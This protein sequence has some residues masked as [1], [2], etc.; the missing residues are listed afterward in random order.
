METPQ[1]GLY[2]TKGRERP[3]SSSTCNRECEVRPDQFF[4]FAE[5]VPDNGTLVECVSK[6][7]HIRHFLYTD[8]NQ[9]INHHSL[10]PMQEVAAIFTVFKNLCHSSV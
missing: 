8:S 4:Y 1:K 2:L 6:C 3:L 5:H 10:S 9:S 7:P